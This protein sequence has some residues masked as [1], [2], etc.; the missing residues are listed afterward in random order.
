MGA[1]HPFLVTDI[2]AAAVV[3][4]ISTDGVTIASSTV[5]VE[6]STKITIGDVELGE[7]T[8]AHDLDVEVGLDVTETSNDTIRNN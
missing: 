6:L 3:G 1:Y 4:D 5:G 2:R 7:I 8:V